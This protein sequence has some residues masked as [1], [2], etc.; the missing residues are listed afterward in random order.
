MFKS[1]YVRG[2]VPAKS[3]KE[4]ASIEKETKSCH[5]VPASAG[6]SV[7]TGIDDAQGDAEANASRAAALRAWQSISTRQ[8]KL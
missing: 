8:S 1:I 5:G 6:D 4:D 7:A 3:G 2:D